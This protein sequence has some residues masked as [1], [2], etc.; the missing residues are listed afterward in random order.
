MPEGA[1][2]LS[3]AYELSTTPEDAQKLV[4]FEP[5]PVMSPYL[6]ALAAGNLRKYDA[7]AAGAAGT[8]RRL[9]QTVDGVRFE[10]YAVPGLEWQ[11]EMASQ[12]GGVGQLW[13]G[14]TSIEWRPTCDLC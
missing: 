9:S 8:G 14:R 12:V 10:F 3:N 1:T 5:T 2:V 11:L 13:V 4:Q 7:A 6:L